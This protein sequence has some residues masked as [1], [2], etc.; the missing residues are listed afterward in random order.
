VS[1]GVE[2]VLA[3]LTAIPNH[4][5]HDGKVPNTVPPV[6]PPY[7]VVYFTIVTPGGEQAPDA[8][9]LI[10]NSDVINLKI[11]THNVGGNAQAARAVSWKVRAA[12]LNVKPVVPGRVCHPI[13][14]EPDEP[15]PIRDESTG[16]LIM[17]LA[18]VY[19]LRSVP[20]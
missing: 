1:A 19:R 10:G 13:R 18:D 14:Q 11:Y 9:D 8:V 3:L 5:I 17:D 16:T 15:A 7:T 4:T 6:K 20:A 2:E 12:L